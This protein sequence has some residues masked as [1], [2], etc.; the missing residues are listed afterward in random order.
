MKWAVSRRT[1]GA[2]DSEQEHVWCARNVRWDTGWSPQRGPQ[3]A[4][5]GLSG[6]HR[7]VWATIRSNDRLLQT[8][9]VSW[10]GRAPDSEQYLSGVR[11]VCTGLSGA[12]IDRKLLLLSNDYICGG[13]VINTH[14][15]LFQGVG[16]Q[17]TYKA[18]CRHFQVLKHPSV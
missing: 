6:V 15:W 5:I 4:L 9:T 16:A 17:A 10:R 1:D 8:P 18:Y 11:S 3:Q 14:S 13:E 2:P 7:T 12:P